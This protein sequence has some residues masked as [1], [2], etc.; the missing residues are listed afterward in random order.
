MATLFSDNEALDF[1]G[2][3]RIVK[4]T[5]KLN[6]I[7]AL[8]REAYEDTTDS[9]TPWVVAYSGG[10][11]STLLLHLIWEAVRASHQARDSRGDTP[12]PDLVRAMRRVYVIANDTLVESPLVIEHLKKS[13]ASMKQ[14]RGEL[15]FHFELTVPP[16][17]DTFWVNVIGRGYIPPSR[18]F[19]W[20]TDR[21]KIYP[22][23]EFLKALVRRHG[24]VVLMVGTRRAESQNR[25]RTMAKYGA[26]ARAMNPHSQ[27][28]GCDML[29]PL[30][31]LEDQDV[32]LTLMQCPPPWSGTH[33]DL[34]NLYKD[35]KGAECPLVLSKKDVPACG[36]TSPRFGCWTCTVVKK[37]KSLM[38]LVASGSREAVLLSKLGLLR[39]WLIELRENPAN[40]MEV[41]RD[42]RERF[43]RNKEGNLDRVYG[44]FRLEVRKQILERLTATEQELGR[45]LITSMEKRFIHSIWHKDE[46]L[47]RVREHDTR[48]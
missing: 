40:R 6:A 43:R 42:G 20:C 9:D 36:S 8:L 34:I 2:P 4:T 32:W 48:L 22:T 5:A 30:A 28:R 3:D 39:D 16:T 23:N 10:K 12:A 29:S 44:P 13:L 17:D 19:R 26:D 47:Y 46:L 1:E 37:D 45:E 27:V 25:A 14:V 24:R 35:A 18:N 31:D 7:R 15:P 33:R 21:M 38:G 11:D 41:R